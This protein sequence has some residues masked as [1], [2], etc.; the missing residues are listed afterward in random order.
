MALHVLLEPSKDSP[1]T[2]IRSNIMDVRLAKYCRMYSVLELIK[3][4]TPEK[5]EFVLSLRHNE[6]A[7]YLDIL[8]ASFRFPFLEEV[9]KILKFLSI[10]P[11]QLAPNG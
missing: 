11:C 1:L 8:V 2:R 5:N 9:K 3:M 7:F 10:A 6:F 4:R